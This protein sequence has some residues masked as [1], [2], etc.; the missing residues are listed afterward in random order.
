M[1]YTTLERDKISFLLP[2][3]ISEAY[4]ADYATM[5]AEMIYRKSLEFN[6]LMNRL[7]EL[8]NRFINKD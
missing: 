1:D 5:Q 8:H 7:N 3:E 2:A 6:D 4:K